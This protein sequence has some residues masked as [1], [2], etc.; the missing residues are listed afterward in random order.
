MAKLDKPELDQFTVQLTPG[1]ARSGGTATKVFSVPSRKRWINLRLTLDNDD[2]KAY[3]AVVETAEGSEIK[4]IRGLKSHLS[5]GNKVVDLRISSRLIQAGDYVV[6]LSGILVG[7]KG[8]EE[9]VEE[10]SFRAVNR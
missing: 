10:Y 5:G 3:A 9:E 1:I 7:N 2:Y 6:K 8:N 4:R